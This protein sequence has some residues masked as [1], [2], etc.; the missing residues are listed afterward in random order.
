MR[1]QLKRVALLAM[2]VAACDAQDPTAPAAVARVELTTTSLEIAAGGSAQLGATP[3]TASGLAV[4]GASVTWS[5]SDSTVA[6]VSGAG[7]VTALS[8]GTAT[9]QAAAA[10]KVATASVRVTASTPPAPV[11]VPVAAIELVPGEATLFP[12][13]TLP[14][15]ATLRDAAGRELRDR[16]VAWRS[17]DDRIATVDSAGVVSAAAAGTAFITA[18]SEV[19]T[20]TITIRVEAPRGP[21]LRVEPRTLD[22]SISDTARIMAVLTDS[23]GVRVHGATIQWTQLDNGTDYSPYGSWSSPRDSVRV[24]GREVGVTR[25]EA[26][27]GG[28]TDTVVIRVRSIDS[29]LTSVNAGGFLT[30]GTD[31]FARTYCWGQ[32]HPH[33]ATY[34][35]A[36]V[37]GA[38]ALRDV[39]AARE[40]ACGLA[41]DGA[42]WCW[43][44]GGQ[45]A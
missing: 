2:V 22:L 18:A 19:R 24:R 29:R 12:G 25:I 31:A 20:A 17:S 21:R 15:H 32:T 3:R 1:A 11:P 6:R 5:S 38:P 42:A 34:A 30:C 23:A 7:L 37:A 41:D 26:T 14:L 27:S 33:M 8:A 36:P 35:P 28:L 9:V 40:H 43:Y 39:I 13:E 10:G 45:G 4:T 44:R 16:A